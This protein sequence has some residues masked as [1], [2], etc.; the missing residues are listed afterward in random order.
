MDNSLHLIKLCV[1]AETVKDLTNWQKNP[2]AKGPDGLPRHVT[3]MWPKREQ[4]L[5]EGGS[6][7]WVF[8]GI[9]LCRQRI[10]RLDEVIREDG[11]RRCGIVLDTEPVRVEPMPKRPFQ[12]WRYLTGE[13]APRDLT[14]GSTANDDLPPKLIA[15]LSEVGIR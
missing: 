12:G 2:R 6:L 5:L 7:Y 4:E 13:Q 14:R 15:A 8:K 9:V 10:L 3:R 1:G 11:I